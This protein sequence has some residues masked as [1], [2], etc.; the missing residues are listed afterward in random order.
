MDDDGEPGI[1]GVTVKLYTK[2]NGSWY[3]YDETVTD[4]VPD[5][6][7]VGEYIDG[8]YLFEDLAAGH[9]VPCSQKLEDDLP[10]RVTPFGRT[11]AEPLDLAAVGAKP[12]VEHV[13]AHLAT[14]ALTFQ[15]VD[16]IQK[17]LVGDRR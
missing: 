12:E 10:E 6:N 5:P 1:N 2:L 9:G 7:N 14:D 11:F 16:E 15:L 3:F 8:F 13:G 17:H 4:R